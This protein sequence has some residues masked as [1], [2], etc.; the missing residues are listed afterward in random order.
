MVI[1]AEE[2]INVEEQAKKD[3]ILGC[4]HNANEKVEVTFRKKDGS[5][6]TMLCTLAESNIPADKA[7]KEGS[8]AKFS[9]AAQRVFDLEKGEWRSFRW[10]S[11]IQVNVD[12]AS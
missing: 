3:W 12:A 4:L 5:E 1:M 9:D 6:R 8:T 2:A 11:V 7:P 10:D